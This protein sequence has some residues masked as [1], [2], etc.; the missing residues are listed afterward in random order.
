MSVRTVRVAMIGCGWI[1]QKH[2]DTLLAEE[3]VE[4]IACVSTHRE[5]GRAMAERARGARLYAGC[6][7]LFAN[8]K[9][10]DAA[11]ISVPP[12]GHGAAETGA[13]RRGVHC[14]I[15]KPI[16]LSMEDAGGINE[17]L[18]ASGVIASVGY[19]ERYRSGLARVRELLKGRTAGIARAEWLGGIPGAP[20]WRRKERSG[21]QV[22]EQSTHLF[23]LLRWFFGEADTVYS[24]PRRGIVKDVPGYSIEDGSLTTVVFHCGVI[25]SVATGCFL[26]DSVPQSVGVSIACTGSVMEYDWGSEVRIRSG[27][28]MERIPADENA[29][30]NAVRAFLHAVRTGDAGGIRSP[31]NDAMRTL[32]LTLAA[33]RSM[34]T[35]RPIA[36][37]PR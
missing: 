37:D 32:E 22:V 4:V 25:A 13:A 2:L 1:A 15:E 5:K 31:Y 20:W 35:G 16:A 8:E 21:G 19:Q 17:S 28:D 24:V 3:G 34:E 18:R 10:L 11:F 14:Y 36:L 33:N 9:T 23:D 27:K 6:E 30:G 7:E 29:H 26:G 12:D